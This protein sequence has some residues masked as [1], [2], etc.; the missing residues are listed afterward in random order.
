MIKRKFKLN[1]AAI[2]ATGIV[3]FELG[4][5]TANAAP[6]FTDQGF[7]D[8]AHANCL[9]V[10]Q[11]A[12]RSC[13]CEQ[14]LISGDRLSKDD[15]EMAYYYWVDKKEYAKRFE[16]KNKSDPKWHAGFAQRFNNLQALIIS[17]CGK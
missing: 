15:K 4:I 3:L 10:Q 12:P 8:A 1:A 7:L 17:A 2:L 11:R 6:Q 14:K 16:K 5:G 9:E 13:I